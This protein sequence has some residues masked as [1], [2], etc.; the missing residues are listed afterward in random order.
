MLL[1]SRRLRLLF[2]RRMIFLVDEKN[3]QEALSKVGYK[4]KEKIKSIKCVV[5]EKKLT[6]DTICAWAILENDVVFYC[7][8]HLSG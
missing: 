5:C 2:S 7:D 8:E 3:L 4:R 1:F 6:L